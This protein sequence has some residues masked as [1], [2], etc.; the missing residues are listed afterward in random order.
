MFYLW[1]L[2]ADL[3]P[4]LGASLHDMSC[5]ELENMKLRIDAVYNESAS[6]H[7]ELF[8]IYK[9]VLALLNLQE[10]PERLKKPPTLRHSKKATARNF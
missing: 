7:A 4:I 1:H 9:M 3:I 2:D 5:V 6:P 8:N 10:R